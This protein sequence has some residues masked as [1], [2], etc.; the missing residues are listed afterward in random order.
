VSAPRTDLAL[1]AHL[2]VTRLAYRQGDDAA[3]HAHSEEQ[4]GYVVSGRFR[5]TLDAG[6]RE[7]GPGEAYVVPAGAAHAFEVIEPGDVIVVAFADQETRSL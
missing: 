4:I 6:A 2:K 7:Y 1:G 3:P 5:L